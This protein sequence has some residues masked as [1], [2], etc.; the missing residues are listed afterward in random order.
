MVCGFWFDL[1]PLILHVDVVIYLCLLVWLDLL[2]CYALLHI[3]LSLLPVL[4]CC[5]GFV[6][7][8]VNPQILVL[9]CSSSALVLVWFGLVYIFTQPCLGLGR[10][11]LVFWVFFVVVCSKVKLFPT[12]LQI[13]TFSLSDSEKES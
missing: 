6:V 5:M 10:V 12:S 2:I 13:Q 1:S 4:L 9:Y 8:L 11:G 7:C 3:R